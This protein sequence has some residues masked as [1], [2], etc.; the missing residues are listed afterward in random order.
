M[1]ARALPGD[2]GKMEWLLKEGEEDIG[3]G[4]PVSISEETEL[5]IE[6]GYFAPR[7]GEEE[8]GLN[9]VFYHVSSANETVAVGARPGEDGLYIT[10]TTEASEK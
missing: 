10:V 6:I 7:S 8:L 3:G 9:Y 4:L 1:C 2:I 5:N